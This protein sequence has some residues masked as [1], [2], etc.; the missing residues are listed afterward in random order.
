M[1]SG[2]KLTHLFENLS[3]R[4]LC[5]AFICASLLIIGCDESY[6]PAA[7][8]A[9]PRVGPGGS[10]SADVESNQA[11]LP[12]V[13]DWTSPETIRATRSAARIRGYRGISAYRGIGGYSGIRGYAGITRR[14][15]SGVA[16]AYRGYG[17]GKAYR[18]IQKS[19]GYRG[20]GQQRNYRGN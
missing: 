9:A 17:S 6:E 7:Y 12:N 5:A 1:N 20:Y 2:I 13:T 4:T 16:K 8:K 14:G 19:S 10:E 18:G 15:Y 11:R 3:F